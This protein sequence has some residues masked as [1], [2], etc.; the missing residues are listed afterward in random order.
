MYCVHVDEVNPIKMVH[1][2]VYVHVHVLMSM[3]V[4]SYNNG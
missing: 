3:F 4:N 2:A 1:Y